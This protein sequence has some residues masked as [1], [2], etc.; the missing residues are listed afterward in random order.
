MLKNKH[1][2]TTLTLILLSLMMLTLFSLGACAPQP[3]EDDYDLYEGDAQTEI[4]TE[5]STLPDMKIA[6]LRSDDLL[7]LRAAQAEDLFDTRGLFVEVVLFDTVEEKH[8]A[9]VAAEVDGLVTDMA[10]LALLWTDGTE[11]HAVAVLQKSPSERAAARLVEGTALDTDISLE[12]TI[13]LH[14]TL[15]E[16]PAHLTGQRVLAVSHD[17]LLGNLASGE[18]TAPEASAEAVAA[19]VGA[20]GQAVG[21]VNAVSADYHELYLEQGLMEH[22]LYSVPEIPTYPFP[23]LPDREQNEALLRWLYDE[24]VIPQGI[25][26]DDLTFVP[27]AP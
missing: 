8:Q 5:V 19:L 25:G 7:P 11:L 1:A 22:D 4:P 24:G 20:L 13:T 23:E 27:N 15:F 16:L 6:A 26:Y 2:K 9:L 21:K 12:E 17:F 10:D 3:S 18:T 14:Q